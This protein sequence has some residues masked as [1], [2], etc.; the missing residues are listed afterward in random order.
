MQNQHQ[1]HDE[2]DYLYQADHRAGVKAEHQ[3]YQAYDVEEDA[4]RTNV[5]YEKHPNFFYGFT[6]GTWQVY[7]CNMWPEGIAVDDDTAAQEAKLDKMAELME[8]QPGMR[9]LDVGC[10]WGGPLTYLCK[11][12]GVSGIGLTLSPIQKA[13]ADSR[14]AAHGVNAEIL[15]CHWKDFKPSQLFD[16]IYTDEVIVHFHDL[17]DFFKKAHAMLRSGGMMV[18]KEVHFNRKADLQNLTRGDAF[19]NQIYGFT[20][21]YHTLYEEL[22]MLDQANF[23]MYHHFQLSRDDYPKTLS[24]WID[25]MFMNQEQMIAVTDQKTWQDFRKYLRLA[26]MM[27]FQPG[28][29]VDIIAAKRAGT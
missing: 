26:R 2:L 24:R 10:G 18:N 23:Y 20:G 15:V 5:H 17:L 9:I 14:I 27:F 16:A 21:N 22:E 8:L 3:L 11:K 7:S 13:A 4:K 1:H 25:N 6:G 19:V 29:S 12:Y 28:S